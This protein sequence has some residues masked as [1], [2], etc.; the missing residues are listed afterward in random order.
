MYKKALSIKGPEL[1][2]ISILLLL[3]AA[4]FVLSWPI[5]LYA[6]NAVTFTTLANFAGTNG[7]DPF[8]GLILGSDGNLYG[9]TTGG[10]TNGGIG[11]FFNLTKN[12][13]LTTLFS[14]GGTNGS[15]PRGNLVQSSDGAFYGTTAQGGTNG[16]GTV[17]KITTNGL[18]TTLVEFNSTNGAVPIGGLTLGNDGAFYGTTAGGG[19]N[20]GNY[21]N[22]AGT[23]FRITTNGAFT[24]LFSFSNTN[25]NQAVAPLTLGSDGNFYGTTYG[26]G[27]TF[28]TNTAGSG[29]VF[30]LATNGTLTSLVSFNS[31]NGA[32][33]QAGMIQGSDGALYGTTLAGGTNNYGTIFKVT[34][35]GTLATL[36][37][38]N[39]A[40][41]STPYGGLVQ[42]RDGAFYGTASQGGIPG[43]GYGPGA[44]YL[45][46]G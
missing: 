19:T 38:F 46:T 36:V 22:G 17:F 43:S 25:G 6:Q 4:Q 34:T 32:Q 2:L 16:V 13:V 26:G 44:G 27:A 18:L 33:P 29:T 45:F 31:T 7:S 3:L 14:F 23:I 21:N 35:N 40:N 24:S 41:G 11:T 15:S 1:R 28:T 8:G 12:G 42:G 10:G 5:E 30:K 39:G 9:T 37:S 20:K